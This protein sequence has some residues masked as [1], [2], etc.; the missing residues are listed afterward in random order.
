MRFKIIVIFVLL[1]S[2]C[3]ASDINPKSVES[4]QLKITQSGVLNVIGPVSHA[5]LTVYIPQ[6]GIEN[7]SVDADSWSI[8]RDEFGNRI[9]LLEWDNPS[10]MI[11]YNVETVVK[12]YAKHLY[13][14]DSGIGNDPLYL[15]ET[16]SIL[17]TD[18][19]RKIAYP[20]EKSLEKAAELTILV[21]EIVKY[22][23]VLKGERKPSDW[24]LANK[25][26]VCTEFSN[27][28]TSLLRI[29]S[30]PARYVV[31]YSYSD[32]DKKFTGHAWVEV[33]LDNGHWVEL[34]P[35]WLESGYLDATHIR[36]AGL[37]DS[38]QT[39]VLS[40]KGN[41]KIEWEKNEDRFEIINYQSR[42]I[43]SITLESRDFSTN[44]HGFLKAVVSADECL[45]SSITASSCVDENGKKLFSIYDD[46]RRFFSCKE[47]ELYWV[48]N[49]TEDYEYYCPVV[50]YD[51]IGAMTEKRISVQET[52]EMQDIFISGPS[53]VGINE[54][55]RLEASP[56]EALSNFLFFSPTLGNSNSKN[57][58][59]SISRPGKYEFYLYSDGAFAEK[60]VSVVEENEFSIAVAIPYNIT[61]RSSFTAEIAVNNL[62]NKEKKAIIKLEFD[63]QL[64]EDEVEFLPGEFKL[65]T[66]NFSANELGLRKLTI[67]ILSDSITSY[68]SSILVYEKKSWLDEFLSG[69]AR[70]FEG[71]VKWVRDSLT[72]LISS[73][74]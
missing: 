52:K 39:E 46:E 70:F 51:Q 23:E 1:S 10:G 35:T 53:T 68:S 72:S 18:D 19:I 69:I 24:V 67:S 8:V 30:I 7:I 71:I 4:L 62:L 6:E 54:K 28:L 55:F 16:D 15:K 5:N 74:Q 13:S 32:I 31:G 42:N 57:W 14:R 58:E 64:E 65:L 38:N 11:N 9:L 73:R 2:A 20:F 12:N 49:I 21:N 43:T 26:G 48:F 33:L 37:L 36:L 40:Y 22:D 60:D 34:D 63:N 27:L 17:F 59:L 44:E 45:I 66:Y 25:R 47:K 41:G 3:F 56:E 29:N 50:V 61:I